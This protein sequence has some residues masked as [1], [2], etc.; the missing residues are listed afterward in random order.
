[1]KITLYGR[2]IIGEH[3]WTDGTCGKIWSLTR[4]DECPDEFVFTLPEGSTPPQFGPMPH[5]EI[6]GDVIW[7]GIYDDFRESYINSKSAPK[8]PRL[9]RGYIPSPSFLDHPEFIIPRYFSLPD[10]YIPLFPDTVNGEPV[11]CSWKYTN[12]NLDVIDHRGADNAEKATV[13]DRY[14]VPTS[15]GLFATREEA[16]AAIARYRG[17]PMPEG[18]ASHD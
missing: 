15:L 14:G 17:E 16:K 1:M 13:Y 2:Y 18:G 11:Y 8:I 4:T 3:Y 9:W 5:P 6:D 12:V 10:L 7:F